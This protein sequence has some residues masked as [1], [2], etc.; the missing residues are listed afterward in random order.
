[1]PNDYFS[2]PAHPAHYKPEL[3]VAMR[4][5]V[6]MLPFLFLTGCA[7]EEQADKAGDPPT[8]RAAECRW[9]DGEMKIDA[10]LNEPAWVKAQ[11]I[12]DFAVY[13]QKRKAKTSTKKPWLSF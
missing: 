8:V 12:Q 6:A 9:A 11:L 1:M 4:R 7:G 13:W 2:P 10:E 3:A 5:L